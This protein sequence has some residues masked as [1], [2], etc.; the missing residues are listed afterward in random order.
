MT[1]PEIQKLIG[2][3]PEIYSLETG[4]WAGSGWLDLVLSLSIDLSALSKKHNAKIR[5]IEFK[6]KFGR[7]KYWAVCDKEVWTETHRLLNAAEKESLKTCELCGCPG[8]LGCDT[9]KYRTLCKA[10]GPGYAPVAPADDP[11]L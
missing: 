3:F 4:Y 6:E 2:L 1:K 8:V 5:C 11:L 9:G 7:L 10:C